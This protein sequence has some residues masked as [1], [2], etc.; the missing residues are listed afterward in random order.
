MIWATVSSWSCFCWLYRASPSLAT[1]NIINLISVLTIWWCPCVKSS[2]VLLEDAVCSDQCVFFAKLLAFALLYFVL[3]GQTCLLPQVSLD[4]L[5]LYSSPLWAKGHLFL[6]LVL[7][8]LVIFIEP[9]NFSFFSITGQGIDL[10][11]CDMELFA[12]ETNR[13]H[14]VTFEIAPKYCILNSF[15]DY[16]GYSI[17]SKG[18]LPTVVNELVTW[19]T[20]MTSSKPS[21]LPNPVFFKHQHIEG[22]GC[23]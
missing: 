11:Y 5:L 3:Q 7:E 17:S 22:L 16:E 23:V 18:F 19:V 2:F 6:V 20:L 15:V 4:F 10:D 21:H 13:D 12:L 14:P 9:F 8:G 1:K